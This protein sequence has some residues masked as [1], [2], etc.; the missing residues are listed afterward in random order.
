MFL[1]CNQIV[2]SLILFVLFL[3]VVW[4]FHK[5]MVSL[6]FYFYFYLISVLYLNFVVIIHKGCQRIDWFNETRYIYI[7]TYFFRIQN[8]KK[9][10]IYV[11]HAKQNSSWI[12]SKILKEYEEATKPKI[13]AL[14]VATNTHTSCWSLCFIIFCF[15]FYFLVFFLWSIF[16]F[17][18]VVFVFNFF[19]FCRPANS[20]LFIKM[21]SVARE[22]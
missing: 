3:F 6:V 11:R 18:S 4:I 1:H 22:A 15:R 8:I 2:Y 20:F 9:K 7:F 5:F 13:H 17:K 12:K 21:C 19:F 16:S 10:S 14:L